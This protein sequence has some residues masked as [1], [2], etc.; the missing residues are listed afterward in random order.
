MD[1]NTARA[2]LRKAAWDESKHPRAEHG[3]FA[4]HA[5]AVGLRGARAGLHGASVVHSVGA[6]LEAYRAGD[7]GGALDSM[8]TASAHVDG[9]LHHLAQLPAEASALKDAAMR[10]LRAAWRGLVR[11]KRQLLGEG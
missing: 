3:H 2:Q 8:H 10:Q 6:G 9:L 1:F 11:F 7:I 4:A 5:G